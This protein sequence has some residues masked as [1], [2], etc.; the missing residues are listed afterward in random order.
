MTAPGLGQ[1]RK[2]NE[3]EREREREREPVRGKGWI[4]RPRDGER[5]GD[6]GREGEHVNFSITGL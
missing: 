6:T 5:V 4:V 2:G 3:R 1:V